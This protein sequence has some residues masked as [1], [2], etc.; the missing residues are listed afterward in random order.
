[1]NSWPSEQWVWGFTTALPLKLILN[2]ATKCWDLRASNWNQPASL[3]TDFE[4]KVLPS[5]ANL[6]LL[7]R[8]RRR[9]LRSFALCVVIKKF[10]ST[11]ASSSRHRRHVLFP[12][13]NPESLTIKDERF[14]L[15]PP[16][17]AVV[18]FVV[19]VFVVCDSSSAFDFD[20]VVSI[21]LGDG[22]TAQ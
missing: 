9:F 13:S 1:M 18:V 4:Q 11:S 20:A 5:D 2:I 3:E 19:D 22:W 7:F 17:A 8:R 14:I 16:F 21:K 12:D 10:A 15:V 6:Q